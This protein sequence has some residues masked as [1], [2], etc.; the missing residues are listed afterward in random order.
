M[1]KS[2]QGRKQTGTAYRFYV[3]G[4]LMLAYVCAFADRTILGLLVDPIKRDLV[5]SDTQVSL[6]AGFAF[7]LFY[8]VLGIP[9]GWLA[10]RTNRPRLILYGVLVWSAMTALCG[11]ARNFTHLFLARIGVG[12]GEATLSPATYSLLPDYFEREQ[13][14][15]ATSIYAMGISIGGG[16]AMLL[17]GMVVEW[18]GT[19]SGISLPVYGTIRPWQAAFIACGASG[20][21][22]A[23]LVLTIREPRRNQAKSA[24]PVRLA[25][26][27]RYIYRER[28]A[29]IP[30]IL[31]YSLMVI[32]SYSL[33]TWV[34]AFL[35]RVHDM[36][37]AST[38]S[39][40]G[41]MLLVGGTMGMLA[42]GYASDRLTARG[43]HDAPMRVCI[44]AMILQ[45]PLF[46]GG[47]LVS[48]TALCLALLAGSIFCISL[49]GGLQGASIQILSP[50][51]I[52]GQMVAVYL[53]FANLIGLGIGPTLTASMTDRIFG[54]PSRIGEALALTS[55][56]S[57]VLA[58]ALVTFGLRAA[59]SLSEKIRD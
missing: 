28:A 53:L 18:L 35:M 1:T 36:G 12:V 10:D 27:F 47:L 44:V 32:P 2:K 37:P 54:D 14:G 41:L 59:S 22:V 50:P 48:D 39:A 49:T 45:A 15:L 24:S 29:L 43:Y 42:G 26:T 16:I 17:G 7:A 55:A 6:L 13:L 23:A 40:L 58:V 38:G 51:A 57:L 9:C 34:P 30:V 5:L 11:L 4:V 8:T 21:M 19:L 25:D 31:G 46:V 52:R 33:V 3:V 56:I 20:L